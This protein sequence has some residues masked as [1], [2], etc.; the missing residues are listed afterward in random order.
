MPWE[1]HCIAF[2][3]ERNWHIPMQHAIFPLHDSNTLIKNILRT[4]L[5]YYV[6]KAF[7][8]H[9]SLSRLKVQIRYPDPNK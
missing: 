2:T 4:G 1:S 6:L 7:F 3:R 9:K 5:L 8:F